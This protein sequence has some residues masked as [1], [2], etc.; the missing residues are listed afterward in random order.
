MNAII[1]SPQQTNTSPNTQQLASLASYLAKERK[2]ERKE[3]ANRVE[4]Q[5]YEELQL[6]LK[7]ENKTF[8][9]WLDEKIKDEI[10][11][12]GS[13]N[14]V[15]S[16]ENWTENPEFVAVPA[17]LAENSFIKNWFMKNK[18]DQKTINEI[19]YK[20]QEWQHLVKEW[21]YGKI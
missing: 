16:L 9:K 1:S 15:Y 5:S 19:K 13:G 2:K 8:T 6:I 21:E 11:V 20:L 12:H 18:S 7:R 4:V 14:P 10:K 17:L 3:I